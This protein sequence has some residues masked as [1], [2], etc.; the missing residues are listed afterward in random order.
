MKISFLP[1]E[2]KFFDMFDQQA[3]C[4]VDAA[5]YFKELANSGVFDATAIQKMRDIEHRGDDLTHAIINNLNKTFI[6]PFDREDIHSLAHELDSVIDLIHTMTNRMRLYKLSGV[7]SDLVQFADLIEKSVVA[8]SNAVRMLRETKNS[9]AAFDACI[10]INRLENMGDQ[11]RDNV[12]GNLFENTHDPIF[13]IKWKEIYEEAETV[14][15]K[16][17]DVANV[18]ESILVKQA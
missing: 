18:V 1:R 5:V 2:F 17:E 3:A 16:C 4:A 14:L 8:L 9:K 10:E 7:N 15:D 11:L 13:I 6:T 12:I